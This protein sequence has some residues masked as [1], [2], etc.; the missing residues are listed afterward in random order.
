VP[1]KGLTS[2]EEGFVWAAVSLLRVIVDL[3][4]AGLSTDLIGRFDILGLRHLYESR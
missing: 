4:G 2:T 1:R 3:L